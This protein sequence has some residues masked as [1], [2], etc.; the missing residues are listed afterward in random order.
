MN[1]AAWVE[2][3]VYGFA[4]GCAVQLLALIARRGQP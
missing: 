2:L 1:A 4:F 3:I